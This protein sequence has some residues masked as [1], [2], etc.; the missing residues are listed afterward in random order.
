M[1]EISLN[2]P[3]SPLTPEQRRQI[4]ETLE[5]DQYSNNPE[6]TSLTG[7]LPTSLD[8]VN[9][10]NISDG[11]IYILSGLVLGSNVVSLVWVLKSGVQATDLDNGF[12]AST[13]QVNRYWEAIPIPLYY[14]KEIDNGL[15]GT[16]KTLDFRNRRKHHMLTL[17]NDVTLTFT[18][19]LEA[20]TIMLK[21]VS[22]AT[23]G[24]TITWPASVRWPESTAPTLSASANVVDLVA[25]YFDGTEY[26]A[27]EIINY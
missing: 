25:L 1:L 4:K 3:G 16:A 20:C 12:V 17:N 15:S 9:T 7:G 2:S 26:F 13:T 14:S 21:L 22:D 23:A 27:S 5:I 6:I 8:G 19:P 11:I 24:H 18:N 10:A